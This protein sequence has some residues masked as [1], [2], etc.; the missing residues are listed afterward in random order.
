[1]SGDGQGQIVRKYITVN[2]SVQVKLWTVADEKNNVV[3]TVPSPDQQIAAVFCEDSNKV[4]ILDL[5][6]LGRLI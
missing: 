1:M 3:R 2:G 4:Y 6:I 5:N